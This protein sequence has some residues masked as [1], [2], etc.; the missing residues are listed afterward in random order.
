MSAG[1]PVG[2]TLTA[3]GEIGRV[4]KILKDLSRVFGEKF[5]FLGIGYGV[6]GISVSRKMLKFVDLATS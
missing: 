2:R 4:S 1:Q 5:N 6:W 3:E